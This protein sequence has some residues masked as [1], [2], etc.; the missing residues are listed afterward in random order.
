MKFK[1]QEIPEGATHTSDVS[2]IHIFY[3]LTDRVFSFYD[4]MSDSWT[5]LPYSWVDDY[6]LIELPNL[7]DRKAFVARCL[8]MVGGYGELWDAGVRFPEELK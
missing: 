8:D 5:D 7:E 1:G 2:Q 4:G 3:R 6:G